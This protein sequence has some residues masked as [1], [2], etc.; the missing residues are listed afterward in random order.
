MKTDIMG[1]LFDDFEVG[2]TVHKAL[3]AL[4]ENK[5]FFIVTPNPEIVNLSISDSSYRAVLN[6]ADVVTPDGIG[7]VYA[8][9][10]L[11]GSIRKRAAGF[12]IVKGIL[13]GL[14]DLGGSVYLF[15]G[16]P[17]V[18]KLAATEIIKEFQNIKI[19]G[20][21]HGYFDDDEAIINDINVNNP[22]LLLVCLGAPKQEMWINKNK[23]VLN[24]GIFIGAGGSI[25]V[26]A[27]KTKRAPELFIK[28][29][30]EWLYRLIKEPK[31]VGRMAKIP[32]FL[33]KVLF[34]RRLKN[35]S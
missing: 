9:K 3:D 20:T 24:A 12:D 19:A 22:D 23:S 18:A 27:G 30:L 29:N 26:L 4:K 15:G 34:K 6:S 21:H 17:G 10:I 5:K 14:N 13:S 33:L 32:V 7:I 1:V 2:Q 16:K 25:D 31:R 35:E 28:L 11:G 8:S